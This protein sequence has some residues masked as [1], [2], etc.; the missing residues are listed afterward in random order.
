MSAND[1]SEPQRRNQRPLSFSGD[2]SAFLPASSN[3]N[4]ANR[5]QGKDSFIAEL[6]RKRSGRAPLVIFKLY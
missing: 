2:A 4:N 5:N 3:L 1:V 6:S